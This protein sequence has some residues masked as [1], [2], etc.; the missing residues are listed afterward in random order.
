MKSPMNAEPSLPE[1][2]RAYLDSVPYVSPE[3]VRTLEKA[4]RALDDD[5]AFQADYYKGLFVNGVLD[6]MTRHALTPTEVSRRLGKSR[7]YVHRILDESKKVNFTIET[8]VEL[9]MVA[10]KR[11]KLELTD[12]EPA[13]SIL[14]TSTPRRFAP[15]VEQIPLASTL[16][17]YLA[18][19]EQLVEP[20]PGEE[21]LDA[22]V[23][24]SADAAELPLAA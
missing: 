4:A 16:M 2:L 17:R 7:Q 10:G 8:M 19:D 9:A 20:A 1:D 15:E 13:A 21:L 18:T 11:I 24:S 6:G 23:G 3:E 12:A 22:Q 5:P 14:R